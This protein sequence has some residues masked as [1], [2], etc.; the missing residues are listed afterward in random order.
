M[1][2][3]PAIDLRG[4]QVVRLTL[5][6]YDR[7]TV[8]AS[9][10]AQIARNFKAAGAKCLHVVDLDGAKDGTQTNLPA[11]EAIM[12]EGGLFVE[13]GGGGRSEESVARY[14]DLGV[15]RVIL[16]T[17]AVEQPALMEKLAAR[18]P[19]R[20]AAGV[21]AKDGF[22]AIHGWRTVTDL[23]A[24]D[25]ASKLP[26]QGVNTVI[27]TDISRDGLLQGANLPAYEKLNKIENLD[28]VASG[29]ISFEHE[30]SALR[31]MNMYAAI[32]GKALYTGK[33][34]LQRVLAIA[35]GEE[36]AAQ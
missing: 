11:I 15:N 2:I 21:D 5:G 1:L 19:G 24:Y 6:D 20:I 33:L 28:V 12:K 27:Y 9:D 35:R 10:P 32:V 13:V 8:Y 25:F 14:M 3:F 26:S 34:N 4:G 31:D 23:N 16:G 30:I 17:M 18:Y 36:A 29:G 22:V 7:M